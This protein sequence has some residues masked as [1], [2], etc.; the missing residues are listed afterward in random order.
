[1]GSISSNINGMRFR[2]VVSPYVF[3]IVSVPRGSTAEVFEG[4]IEKGS[5]TRPRAVCGAMGWRRD[6]PYYL[7]DIHA[8]H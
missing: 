1:M 5:A 3:L 7:A 2:S 8:F 6:V 4:L